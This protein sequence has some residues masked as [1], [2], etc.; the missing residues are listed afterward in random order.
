M[1]LQAIQKLLYQAS[2]ET[3]NL[4]GKMGTNFPVEIGARGTIG[5]LVMKEIEF[6][7]KIKLESSRKPEQHFVDHLASRNGNYWPSFGFLVMT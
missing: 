5:S 6:S 1:S 3:T 2:P 4:S 7:T